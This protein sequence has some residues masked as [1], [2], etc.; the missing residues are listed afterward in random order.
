MSSFL[1]NAF[2]LALLLLKLSYR[3]SGNSDGTPS[4]IIANGDRVLDIDILDA[5]PT[6]LPPFRLFFHQFCFLKLFFLAA[7]VV[8]YFR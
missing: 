5:T 3:A 7:F 1:I 4:A 2:P 6:I 8:L